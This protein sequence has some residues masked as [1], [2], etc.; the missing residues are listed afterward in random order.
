MVASPPRWRRRR[1]RAQGGMRITRPAVAVATA[2]SGRRQ[3][4]NPTPPNEPLR[5]PDT[6]S[7]GEASCPSGAEV[8]A[9]A[10]RGGRHGTAWNLRTHGRGDAPQGGHQPAACEHLSALRLGP[11]SAHGPGTDHR[12]FGP[13]LRVRTALH[14]G[15]VPD[16]SLV[17]RSN[18]VLRLPY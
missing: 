3:D 13:Q 14:P 6:R 10:T 1:R 15:L 8:G 5:P 7:L 16:L 12:P 17:T 4:S 9:S 18:T 11:A 2:S